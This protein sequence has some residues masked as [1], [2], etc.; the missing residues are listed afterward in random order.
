MV[1]FK[2]LLMHL[3]MFLCP[4]SERFYHRHWWRHWHWGAARSLR[5]GHVVH[6]A[7]ASVQDHPLQD[8]APS[9]REKKTQV[10]VTG[11]VLSAL[12]WCDLASIPVRNI[13]RFVWDLA[14]GSIC[15]KK[16]MNC[17]VPFHSVLSCAPMNIWIRFFYSQHHERM[18]IRQTHSIGSDLRGTMPRS[19]PVGECNERK[20]LCSAGNG[21]ILWRVFTYSTSSRASSRLFLNTHSGTGFGSNF[22]DFQAARG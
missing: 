7:L 1:K 22:K 21:C 11:G 17:E 5:A 12:C 9:H 8:P 10:C 3:L 2:L 18:R 20:F 19:I 16:I 6:H 13:F 15:N 4:G 14:S